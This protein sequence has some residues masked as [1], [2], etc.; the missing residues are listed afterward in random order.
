MMWEQHDLIWH[1]RPKIGMTQLYRDDGRL[2]A[3]TVIEAGPAVVTQVKTSER[4]GYEAVQVGF[5]EA[6][7][8]NGPERGHLG[9]AASAARGGLPD[10]SSSGRAHN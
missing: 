2:E 6:K 4:D 3:A 10:H 8:L 9:T 5:G 7:R 1:S